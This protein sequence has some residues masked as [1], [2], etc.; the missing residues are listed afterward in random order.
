[1]M[2]EGG[3]SSISAFISH[4]CLLTRLI[5][6]AITRR[7]VRLCPFAKNRVFGKISISRKLNDCF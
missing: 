3:I 5:H 2:T 6:M 1:M 4:G 7:A